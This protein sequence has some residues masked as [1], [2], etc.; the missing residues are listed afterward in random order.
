MRLEFIKQV[1]KP[2]SFKCT[3]PDKSSTYMLIF[4][5]FNFERKLIHYA[6]ESVLGFNH[7]YFGLLSKGYS[8]K[9]FETPLL[10]KNNMLKPAN[11]PVQAI[12]SEIL[13][14]LFHVELN[15][16]TEIEDFLSI[17]KIT[18]EV[19][20]IKFPKLSKKQIAEVREKIIQLLVQWKKLQT[21]EI[22]LL[23]FRFNKNI[24]KDKPSKPK[25]PEG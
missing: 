25:L 2:V 20:Q 8:L 10:F 7:A 23:E 11:L 5:P 24:S 16:N 14:G 12:Q 18:F 1:H 17:A 19:Q 6:I 21:G 22:L 4:H 9:D 3:R 13:A 15:D